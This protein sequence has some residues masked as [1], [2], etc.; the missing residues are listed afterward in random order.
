MRIDVRLIDQEVYRFM[1]ARANGNEVHVVVCDLPDELNCSLKTAYRAI[2]RLQA[3]GRIARV[4]GSK[5][6]GHTYRIVG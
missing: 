2:K 1:Q 6:T 4:D 3:A 5:R